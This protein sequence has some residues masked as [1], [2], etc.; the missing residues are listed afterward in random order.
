G[1]EYLT[2]LN[3]PT[4][5]TLRATRAFQNVS[6]SLC[7]VALSLGPGEGGAIV[8][9]RYDVAQ[10]REGEQQR[11]LAQGI[12]PALAERPGIA[13]VHLCL[14][15]RAAS[16]ID[17]AEKRVRSDKP[18]IPSWVVLVEGGGDIARLEAA[19]REALPV[20]APGG[21]GRRHTHRARPLP[22]SIRLS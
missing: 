4:P 14:A 18:H 11:L 20:E 8:T 21:G 19:C 9:W 22:A 6:R 16:S 10:G 3:N 2:R 12:L 5:W 15:D 13:G 1:A 17:T 7:R